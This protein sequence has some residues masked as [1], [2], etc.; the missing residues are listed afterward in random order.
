MRELNEKKWKSK[1]KKVKKQSKPEKV[2]KKTRPKIEER[3]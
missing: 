2:C 1:K 3:D